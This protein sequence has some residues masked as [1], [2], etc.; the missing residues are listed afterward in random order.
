[1]PGMK[2]IALPMVTPDLRLFDKDLIRSLNDL[3]INLSALLDGGLQFADNM[4][5]ELVTF[6]SS[7]T[8][9]AENAVAHNLKR[10]PTGYIVYGLDKAAIVYSG[11]SAWTSTA[12]YLKVNVATVAAEILVF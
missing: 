12:I 9:D 11:G 3:L 5:V 6:N 2:R 4:N 10:V 7:G 1:M 8:P